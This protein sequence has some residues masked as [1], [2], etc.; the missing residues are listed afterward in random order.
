MKTDRKKFV[1]VGLGEV[2]WDILPEDKKLGGAPTNFAYHANCLGAQGWL[3]SSVGRDALGDEIL[4]NID[5]LGLN[6]DFVCVNGD[7]P[8]GTVTA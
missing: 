7:Y 6:R 4:E 1:A 5:R 8:T 3:V 2:L